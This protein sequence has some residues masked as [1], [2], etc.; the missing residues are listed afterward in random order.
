[1]DYTSLPKAILHDHLDGGVRVATVIEL[2]DGAGYAQLPTTDAVEL[3]KW[4][5]QGRSGSLELYLEAFE[6]TY[7]VM[8]NQDAI[9]RVAYEAGVD[10][11]ADGVVYAEVRFGPSLHTLDG[12]K[13][14]DAIEAVLD[15]FDSASRETGIVVY[16]IATALRQETDSEEVANAAIL[17]TTMNRR[18]G[19]PR[20]TVWG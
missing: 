9:R 16:G 12:L 8:Q 14:E 5:H 3:A 18:A 17:R 13:R 15:G 2:A 11:A 1:M 10:L 6:H 20:N 7:G 19:S 4:F